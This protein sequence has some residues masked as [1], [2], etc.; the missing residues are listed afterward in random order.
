MKDGG[1][2]AGEAAAAAML[3]A[4]ANDGRGGPF[5]FDI[6]TGAGRWRPLTPTALDPTPWV[7]NVRPFV[8]ETPWQLRSEGPNPLTSRAYARDFAE[9]KRLGSLS[10][11]ARTA[12][13]TKAA[14]FWQAQPMALYGGAMRQ[15][16]AK[17]HLGIAANARLFA[18]VSLAAAD[19]AISCWNDKYH[20]KFWRPIAAIR[21]AATDGN[22]ATVADPEWKPLFDPSTV[23]CRRAR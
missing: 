11:S 17:R 9:V 2:A 10:S 18:M 19:G 14:I 15:L 6:G 21:E 8:L 20:W 12:D 1:I 13:Q 22:P 4:R 23:T 7:G 3:A 16:S 5:T